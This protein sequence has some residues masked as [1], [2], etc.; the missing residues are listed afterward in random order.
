MNTNIT[1]GNLISHSENDT[2]TVAKAFSRFI[3][4]NT[5]IGLN[6]TLGSGKT[7]FVQGVCVALGAS[8]EE[9]T[10]P[11]FVICN[12][13]LL[14]KNIFHLDAYRIKDDDEF[15]ELGVDEMFLGNGYVFIEWAD[16]FEAMLP[17]ERITV[18]IDV[19]GE[20]TRRFCFSGTTK[21]ALAIKQL[22]LDCADLQL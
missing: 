10:S 21:Y 11:T 9:V 1:E 15:F 5:T 6:G 17:R 20:N 3:P 19:L 14:D 4:S 2:D 12:Q 18:T 8:P 13:Y 7:R 22:L 16:K